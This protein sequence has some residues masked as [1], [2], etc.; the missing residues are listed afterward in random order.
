MM[1]DDLASVLQGSG[2]KTI[3]AMVYWTLANAQIE[4]QSFRE[5]MRELGLEAAVGRDPRPATLLSVAVQKANTGSTGWLLRRQGAAWAVIVEQKT[6]ERLHFVHT[7]NVRTGEGGVL[8]WTDV[9]ALELPG[10]GDML[11]VIRERVAFEYEKAKRL[12]D[13]SELSSMLVAALA[14]R[15]LNAISLRDRTGGLYFVHGQNVE[16]MRSLKALVERLAPACDIT[17]MTLTGDAE[18]LA[19]A[20][21]AARSS[22]GAQLQTL[23]D[24]LGEFVASL[25]Q[26][27]KAATDRN[28]VVRAEKL[29]A[30]SDRVALFSDILGEIAG[31]LN[32]EIEA[33]KLQLSA[34]LG[35]AA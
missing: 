2:A 19:A 31:E 22:F 10:G 18:N 26:D 4:R 21:R 14:E 23:K 17:V 30:L 12:I 27:G 6:P 16:L 15:E 13:T 3:G 5:E 20:A 9:D 11:A 8:E 1:K 32:Q 29:G 35:I 33:A 34:D 7:M 24:E 28:Y 25:K